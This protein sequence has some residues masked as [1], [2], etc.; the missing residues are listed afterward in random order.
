MTTDTRPDSHHH[1]RVIERAL[2]EIDV[3]QQAGAPLSLATLAARLGMSAGHFQR[4]FSAWVGVSP[5]CCLQYLAPDL[6]RDLVARKLPL[7]HAADATGPSGT[8]RLHDLFLS[9]EAMSPGAYA[10]GGAGLDIL[11]GWFESPF[12]PALIMGTKKGI[13]GIGFAAG[14]GAEATMADLLSRWPQAHFTE[15]PMTLAPLA[16]AAFP[17]AGAARG[18][19]RLYLIGTPF[20]IK[21]WA[22]LMAI[23]SGQVTTLFRHYPGDRDTP[24]RCAQRA[25]QWDATRSLS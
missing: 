17:R 4:T 18:P 23:P 5:K 12:G 20:Q 1:F 25:P 8:G 14:K 15:D 11:W 24:G 7:N 21:V 9:W 22:A 16:E 19:V 6:A 2:A 10:K 3:A 13:C